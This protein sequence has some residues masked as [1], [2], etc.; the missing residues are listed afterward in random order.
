MRI[1]T[2]DGK[3]PSQEA[4]GKRDTAASFGRD[5]ANLGLLIAELVG[6]PFETVADLRVA[7]SEIADYLSGAE[8]QVLRMM[9]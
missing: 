3:S 7:P 6:A 4:T 2:I 9:L 5:W 1:A 8:V